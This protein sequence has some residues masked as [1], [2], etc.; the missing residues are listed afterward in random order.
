[1]TWFWRSA[2]VALAVVGGACGVDA[3]AELSAAPDGEALE[4]GL[5]APQGP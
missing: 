1:M 2:V 3:S 4:S 5:G